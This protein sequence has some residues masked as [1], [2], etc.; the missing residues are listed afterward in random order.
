[1]PALDDGDGRLGDGA[2]LADV[3]GPKSAPPKA[4]K[5]RPTNEKWTLSS[6]Q[7]RRQRRPAKA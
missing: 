7:A 5:R 2:G 6:A 3:A 4:L 1:V